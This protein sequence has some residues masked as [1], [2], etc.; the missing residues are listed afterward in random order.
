M[1]HNVYCI[2]ISIEFSFIISKILHSDF[3]E[4]KKKKLNQSERPC[5]LPIT[6]SS[7]E[8]AAMLLQSLDKCIHGLFVKRADPRSWDGKRLIEI[9]SRCLP[10][11][12]NLAKII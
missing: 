10:Q 5:Y 8:M 3:V 7:M 9:L 2:F 11:S 4:K 1:T 6:K 12:D